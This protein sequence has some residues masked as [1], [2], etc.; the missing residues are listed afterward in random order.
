MH[1]GTIDWRH[2]LT[3]TLVVLFI[4]A[5]LAH[6]ATNQEIDKSLN[7][8]KEFLYSKQTN[9]NWEKSPARNEG[10]EGNDRDGGQWGGE[11]ALCVY[12]LLAGGENPQDPRLLPAIE[13]L[14]KADIIGTYALAMRAQ[15]WLNL[16]K[17]P[18]TRALMKKDSDALR[19]IMHKTGKY[20]GFFDYVGTGK[21]Y[22][23]SRSQ[24]G[25]LGMWAAAQMGVPVSPD[26]WKITEQAWINAQQPDGGWKYKVESRYQS[27][28][29]ITAVGV[30]T[31]YITQDYLHANQGLGCTGNVTSPA[32]DKG[33]QWMVDHF[34]QVATDQTYDRDFPYATL[35][36]VERIG[37]AS[38]HK[39]F[40]GIDWYQKGADWLLKE[41]RKD[42]SW[43]EGN[44]TF[45][46]AT[47]NTSF[48]ILFLSRGR[49]PIAFNKLQ[50]TASDG[51][52][53]GA[54]NQ[55]PRD[56][57]NVTRWIGQAI[58]RDLNWQI[59]SIAAPMEDLH[60]SPMLYVSGK[61]EWMP[62]DEQ[63]AK[64]QEFLE[65]GGMI[66][67]NADCGGRAF[68]QSVQKLGE[69]LFPAYRF[70]EIPDDHP[71]YTEQQFRRDKWRIKPSVLGLSNGARELILLVPTGDLG[72]SWQINVV[73]GRE[74]LWQLGANIFQY[75]V[76]KR[77]LNLKGDSHL[78]KRDDAVTADRE[79]K[80]AR[81]QYDGN[82][83]PEPG[84]WR[85]IANVLHNRAKTDLAII[86]VT[87]DAGQ[88]TGTGA[89]IA[90]ITGAGKLA[91]NAQQQAELKKFIDAGGTLILD[92]AGGSSEF[93]TSAEALL[94]SLFPNVK[95]ARL[96]LDHPLY[97][98][99]N[100]TTQ[101]LTEVSYRPFAK[102]RLGASD[103]A[104]RIQAIE[105]DGR[106]VALY[107]REDLSTGLVGRP[108]DGI[109]GYEPSSATD[110][111]SRIL[112]HVSD[113]P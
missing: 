101:P 47:C 93:S 108:I 26:F 16:P 20:R 12:A 68:A 4:A 52:T 32:I 110:L 9:G 25:V 44:S 31:L 111:M 112:L 1:I 71:I 40:G 86:A 97:A 43:A 95:L 60:E 23:L 24:Y 70:R 54:W 21:T 90:H 19:G 64:I 105:L 89:K 33:M 69:V 46:P 82:W 63:K 28:P 104:P 113:R 66:L 80:V 73:G 49:S 45:I 74:D 14:K 75:A 35:Y 84:G 13:F 72:K 59:V 76:D 78:V 38:G 41:Q 103:N 62:T 39:H 7:R 81:L 29:G 85:R 92:S 61:E 88:L 102:A 91:L 57:A 42:G 22:S 6:A 96:P 98:G 37:V 3:V 50:Y 67:A 100:S 5:P 15:V 34:D 94:A 56:V 27:T 107:S 77:N 58:E 36:A 55:R 48:G 109:I 8:A 30:A 83:N 79:I 18:E 17:T 51:T 99:G 65:S 11:T 106:I 10:G 2:C 53:P 87:L